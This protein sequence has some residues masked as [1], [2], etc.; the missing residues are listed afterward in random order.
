MIEGFGLVIS[1][2]RLLRYFPGR[3]VAMARLRS[4]RD[5]K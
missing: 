1:L 2:W 4:L 3:T 5:D